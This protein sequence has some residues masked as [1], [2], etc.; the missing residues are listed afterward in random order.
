VLLD[1]G[2]C[3]VVCLSRLL[4]QDSGGPRETGFSSVK[5]NESK[6]DYTSNMG[7]GDLRQTE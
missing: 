5:L 7:A 3:R 2:F 1:W 6:D 4:I